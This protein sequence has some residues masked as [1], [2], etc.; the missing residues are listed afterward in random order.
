[1]NK[2]HLVIGIVLIVLSSYYA[3]KNVSLSEL[4]TAFKSVRYIYLIPAILLVALTFIFRAMRWRY[5][6][7][8]VKDVK[9]SRL[10]SPLMVGFM[11][12]ILPARAGELV[13]AYL[14]GKRENISFSASFATIFVERLMDMLMF[15]LMLVGVLFFSADT[16][17]QGA[18]GGNHDLRG[19]MIKFGWISFIGSVGIFLFS[20][21][22]QYKNDW[23]V[24]IVDFCTKPLSHKWREKIFGMVHSFTEGLKILKDFRGF[25]AS[26]LLSILVWVAATLCYYPLY[27]AFGIEAGLPMIS[28]LIIL[29]L[30]VGIFISLF[31]TPGFLGAFQAACVVAL[32]DLFGVSKAVAVSYGIIAWLVTMGFIIIV[33]SIFIVKDN[34]SFSEIT[35]SKERVE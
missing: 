22:L 29:C 33:G 7:R 35:S 6:V 19:Y 34:I 16:F 27:L 32:H 5:L 31:P 28:S 26:L 10:F 15:L 24:K 9:T 17:S 4:S 21:L 12:N 20:V 3:F 23:A 13:R 1:M 30:T 8:S 18:A 14:L 2:K 11:G 25:T